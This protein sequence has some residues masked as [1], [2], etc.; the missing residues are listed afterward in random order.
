[1]TFSV[2]GICDKTGMVGVSISSSS[3][4]V[5]S[6]CPWVKAGVGAASTQN[7]TD[8]SLGNVMLRLIEK[9]TLSF[10]SQGRIFLRA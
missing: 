2:A 6:R 3:I 1:M 5:A 9:G 4:S 10:F 8:P 7:I